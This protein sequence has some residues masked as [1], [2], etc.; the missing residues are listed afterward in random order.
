MQILPPQNSQNSPNINNNDI[1]KITKNKDNDIE[2]LKS[3]SSINSSPI[4]NPKFNNED[5]DWDDNAEEY[6]KNIKKECEICAEKCLKNAK[7]RKKLH[8]YLSIPTILIPILMT[9]VSQ[10]DECEMPKIKHVTSSVFIIISI[11]NAINTYFDN[12]RKYE[13]LMQNK[14]KYD[15]IIEEIK[16]QFAKPAEFRINVNSMMINLK[17]SFNTLNRNSF[18]LFYK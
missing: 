6:I 16:F 9:P 18:G 4:K 12:S 10:I 14:Y 13:K 1:S 5:R 7:F 8:I 3:I 17:H 2:F 15:E 11:L